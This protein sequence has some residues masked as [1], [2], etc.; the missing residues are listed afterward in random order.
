[1]PAHVRENPHEY[2]KRARKMPGLQ[3]LIESLIGT[4]IML[5]I[6]DIK[7]NTT[8]DYLKQFQCRKRGGRSMHFYSTL[9]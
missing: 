9:I 6:G 8:N 2:S 5:V 1:M 4:G 3:K 7:M